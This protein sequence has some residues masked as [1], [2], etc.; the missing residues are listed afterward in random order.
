MNVEKR[1]RR[2]FKFRFAILYPLGVFAVL[3]AIPDDNSIRVSIGFIVSGLLI[4]IWANGYAIKTEKLTT[5]GPYAFVRHPLYLGTMLLAVGFI[6]MLKIYSIGA[7]FII[8]MAIVYYHTIKKE[9][10]MLETKFKEEYLTYKKKVPPIFPKVFP[11]HEGGKWSFSLRRL[12]QSQEYKLF[13][14]VIILAILFHLKA[15]CIV[16]HE[17]MDAKMWG[18]VLVAFILGITDLVG[19]FVKWKS[20]LNKNRSRA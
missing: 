1:L 20:R 10:A 19:E 5:C 18:A 8:P 17:T 15:E 4:R 3:F 13:F 14:W 11:Y 16:E 7:V 2:L 6:I 12:M 9:E